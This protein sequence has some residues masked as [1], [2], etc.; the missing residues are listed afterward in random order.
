MIRYIHHIL[1]LVAGILIGIVSIAVK[2]DVITFFTKIVL[3]ILSFYFIG[4]FVR[5]M[6]FNIMKNVNDQE[7]VDD[8]DEAMI[9][10]T[11][12]LETTPQNLEGEE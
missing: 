1:A 10:E 6:L 12:E 8:L 7:V 4:L 5:K 3:A 2:D 9:D 11:E